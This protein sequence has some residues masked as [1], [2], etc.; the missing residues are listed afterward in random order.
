MGWPEGEDQIENIA[1][2]MGSGFKISQ[3]LKVTFSVTKS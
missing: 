2:K 1:T 3:L